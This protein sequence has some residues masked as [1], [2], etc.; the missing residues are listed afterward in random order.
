M[1]AN[2]KEVLYIDVDEEITSIV[3]KVQN[4]S[5]KIVALVLPKRA[6]VLQ[7]IVNMKLLK[8]AADQNEKQAVLIT[9]EARLLPLAG[10][11]KLFVAPNLTSKPYIPPTPAG[12]EDANEAEDVEL[13]PKTPVSQVAPEAKYADDEE[14]LEIDNTPKKSEEASK[15]AKPNKPKKKIPNFNSFRK[16]LLLATAVLILLIGGVV[17]GLVFAPKANIILKTQSDDFPAQLDFIADPNATELDEE[18]SVVPAQAKEIKKEDSETVDAT[19]EKNKGKKASGTVTLRNCGKTSEGAKTIPAG[20]GL[21]SDG[22]TFVTQQAVTLPTSIYSE[23]PSSDCIS[24]EKKVSVVAQEAGDEYNLSPRNYSVAGNPSV[25]ATGGSMQGGTNKIVKTVSQQDIDSA[26]ERLNS[27]GNSVQDEM[28]KEFEEAGYVAITESFEVTPGSYNPSPGLNSE[29]DKVTVSVTNTYK[30]IAVKKDDLKK[31][32]ENDVK[33][34]ND[35]EYQTLLNDG[36]DKAEF[37]ISGANANLSDGQVAINFQSTVVVGPDINQDQLKEEL[38][39]KK[40]GEA[41]DLLKS[42]PG[43]I[44]PKVE[45]SPFW[46]TS[47]PGKASKVTFEIQQADGSSINP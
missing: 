8:K 15:A 7:S 35:V 40:K 45:L 11:A 6:A 46:V 17:Y 2:S 14:P 41:E 22:F 3:S 16:K 1:S 13:D 42:R 19:G 4:S 18:N 34:E 28:K 24:E 39:G 29:A 5:K 44:D 31:L 26:K 33:E 27:K 36:I 38:A 43:V 37:K 32:I 30:M 23:P 47:I 21:S 25:N 9:S 12:A 20:T 10:A